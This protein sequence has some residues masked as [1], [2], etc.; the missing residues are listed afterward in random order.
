MKNEEMAATE[1][2]FIEDY[3]PQVLLL[4]EESEELAMISSTI[5]DFVTQKQDEWITGQSDIDAEWED[6]KAQLIDMGVERYVAIYQAACDRYNA[7]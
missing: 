2:Y 6:Y 4:P 1:E 3:M 5:R 7:G